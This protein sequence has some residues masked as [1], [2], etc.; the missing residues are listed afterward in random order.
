MEVH[1]KNRKKPVT[2]GVL[3]TVKLFEEAGRRMSMDKF[4]VEM[5][6]LYG[7]PADT[8]EVVDLYRSIKASWRN[9]VHPREL[10][11]YLLNKFITHQK[12]NQKRRLFPKPFKTVRTEG[13]HS[14]IGLFFSPSEE[15]QGPVAGVFP[16]EGLKPYQR[17]RYLSVPSNGQVTAW[18]DSFEQKSRVDLVKVGD[19][20]SECSDL[21]VNGSVFMEELGQLAISTDKKELIFY[22]C[23]KA[24]D[25]FTLK[26][27]FIA[28]THAIDALHYWS[29]G[30]KAVFSFGDEGGCLTV[31][32]S[33][34]VKKNGLFCSETCAGSC[35]KDYP[36]VSTLFTKN[37][38]RYTSFEIPVFF[39]ACRQV[40]YCPSVDVFAVCGTSSMKMGLVLM[41]PPGAGNFV[42]IVLDSDG[43]LGFFS[44]VAFSRSTK[45]LLTGGK[46][47]SI[48]VWIP[49]E[50]TPESTLVG[51]FKPVTHVASHPQDKIFVSLSEDLTVR[52]W[53]ES[54]WFCLQRL[55]VRDMGLGR[56]SCM[57][58]NLRNNEL[59]LANSNIANCLGKGT[60]LFKASL[61]SHEDPVQALCYHRLFKL[62][63]SACRNG[64]VTV[65]DLGT[66][67]SA[68]EFNAC[69]DSGRLA[70]LTID[71]SGRRLITAAEDGKLRLW[72]LGSGTEL[73]V[74]PVTVPGTVT[75]LV[76]NN[77]RVFVSQKRSRVIYNLGVNG[78]ENRFLEHDHLRDVSSMDA[79]KSTLVT[80]STNGNVVVWDVLTSAALLWFSATRSPRIHPLPKTDQ[81]RTGVVP[82]ATGSSN[83][84]CKTSAAR[85][86][87]AGRD[88]LLV[89]VLKSRKP[90]A[91]TATVLTSTHGSI[92][93][94]SSVRDGGLLGR[95]RALKDEGGFITAMYTDVEERTLLTGDNAGH[96]YL[97]DIASFGLE[98]DANWPS[99]DTEGWPVPAYAPIL[100]ASWR[101]HSS[102]VLHVYCDS[103]GKYVV[104]AGSDYNVKLWTK[105][106]R[107]LGLF[108]QGEWGIDTKPDRPQVSV[109]PG[110]TTQTPPPPCADDAHED[111]DDSVSQEDAESSARPD[112]KP[113]PRES[114]G[115]SHEELFALCK[116]L[117]PYRPFTYQL[118]KKKKQ[119]KR[120]PLWQLYNLKLGSG[121]PAQGRTACPQLLLKR[122]TKLPA[123]TRPAPVFH[124]TVR[125]YQKGYENAERTPVG[126]LTRHLQSRHELLQYSWPT[127]IKYRSHSV[128]KPGL[129]GGRRL[130]SGKRRDAPWTSQS[131]TGPKFT[132]ENINQMLTSM[133]KQPELQSDMESDALSSL[134]CDVAQAEGGQ[135][136]KKVED[137]KKTRVEG[138]RRQ[139]A[140]FF[141]GSSLAQSKRSSKLLK[142]HLLKLDPAE[143]TSAKIISTPPSGLPVP[144]EKENYRMSD[145]EA[146]LVM[147][148]HS[149]NQA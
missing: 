7:L 48:R 22:D 13:S 138:H 117:L 131:A 31:L 62:V 19:L 4:C 135:E 59:V 32:I 148:H 45:R 42:K 76:C 122:C 109:A 60:D 28:E 107:L 78:C 47:G 57:H 144:E 136:R 44:C 56:I 127:R 97:W 90:G 141:S 87:A 137:R 29:D 9:T 66:G 89:K 86:N 25:S 70:A 124:T 30:T 73:A 142:P 115:F 43:L 33:Y 104:S 72:T 149:G 94:W 49:E 69:A 134:E 12:M 1:P 102:D 2:A 106:G 67:R 147:Y 120:K 91:T 111:G 114:S 105:A 65:W 38:T 93:A 61:T 123:P 55:K 113:D 53:S 95:F 6:R 36:P 71:G 18:S 84:G 41:P 50:R 27:V 88:G 68:V 116:V 80:G 83:R 139:H 110:A 5:R 40:Q 81:G 100:L 133:C 51:H 121:A 39:D 74:L 128:R 64:T 125:S 101:G 108:G 16:Q 96:I 15:P 118:A 92:Y 8:H 143:K 14:I 126:I 17:G 132:M 35:A 145:I 26:H 99:E 21:H 20:Y 24:L 98:A 46:D 37:S 11:D 3:E 10:S 130:L 103:S 77:S 129:G 82:D 63:V 34:S 52:V 54:S 140:G 119:A 112:A 79:H 58:Y 85:T 75:A 146:F 23:S